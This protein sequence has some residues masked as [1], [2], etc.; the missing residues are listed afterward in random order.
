MSGRHNIF[1]SFFVSKINQRNMNKTKPRTMNIWKNK[2]WGSNLGSLS[3]L[4]HEK[5]N[6]HYNQ[7]NKKKC[8]NRKEAGCILLTRPADLLNFFDEKKETQHLQIGFQKHEADP[9]TFMSV[10][11]NTKWPTEEIFFAAD[12]RSSTFHNYSKNDKN[13]IEE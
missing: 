5:I 1:C 3:N 6:Y 12:S 8:W 4:K 11:Y 10:F 2:T 7:T 9:F 13:L